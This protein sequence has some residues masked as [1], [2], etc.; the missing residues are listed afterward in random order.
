VNTQEVRD[1]INRYLP[2]PN[3]RK[4][5]L[6]IFTDT[7]I[8]ANIASPASWG[9]TVNPN[10]EYAVRLTVGM[11]Y[12]CNIYLNGLALTLYAP[13]QEVDPLENYLRTE[14]IEGLNNIRN[15]DLHS[16]PTAPHFRS[17]PE[18]VWC[19]FNAVDIEKAYPIVRKS[20]NKII[21]ISSKRLVNPS[22]RNTHK[23]AVADYLS[24]ELHTAIP[25]PQYSVPGE[26]AKKKTKGKY[27]F[28]F[29][30]PYIVNALKEIEKRDQSIYNRHQ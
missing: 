27:A 4:A 21:A 11:I 10:G 18:A 29:D 30:D 22:V 9:I 23:L 28:H 6:E 1:I 24:E 15:G 3:T 8:K 7:I 2:E 17:L 13:D 14:N 12:V 25:Q 20:Y 19:W 5:C 26:K 16:I